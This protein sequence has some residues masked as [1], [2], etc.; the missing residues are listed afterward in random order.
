MN[1][2][3]KFAEIQLFKVEVK[4]PWWCFYDE[5]I[6]KM[7]ADE[8]KSIFGGLGR[9]RT[10]CRSAMILL[11]TNGD[12]PKQKFWPGAPPSLSN[13]ALENA[14]FGSFLRKK[15]H[16]WNCCRNFCRNFWQHD[17]T[18]QSRIVQTRGFMKFYEL[19][20][21]LKPSKVAKNRQDFAF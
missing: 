21:K 14:N 16:F 15:S 3:E 12:H 2:H 11:L 10:S 5:F 19:F 6:S 1:F 4:W 18:L 7:C 17:G 13:R 20:A 9:S 8:S